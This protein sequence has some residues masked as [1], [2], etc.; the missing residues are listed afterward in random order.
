MRLLTLKESADWL[1]LRVP[2]LRDWIWRRKIPYV[3][4]GRSVRI[5]EETIEQLIAEGTVPARPERRAQ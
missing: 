3:K 1:G 5:A 4:L 2:T